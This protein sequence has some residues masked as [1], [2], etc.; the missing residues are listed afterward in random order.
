MD[1]ELIKDMERENPRREPANR[2]NITACLLLLG[3]FWVAL[4]IIERFASWID[5]TNLLS[6]FLG[7][8]MAV[9]SIAIL[10]SVIFIGRHLLY[11]TLTSPPFSVAILVVLLATTISGTLIVQGAPGREF[12]ELYGRIFSS[13]LIGLGMDDIFHSLWFGGF[14]FLL[15]VTLLLVA[16]K[17]KMWKMPKWGYLLAHLGVVL[18]LVGGFIGYFTGFKGFMDLHEGMVA[19]EVM[20]TE[21]AVRTGDKHTLVFSVLLEDFDIEMYESEYRLYVYE[22]SGDGHRLAKSFSLDEAVEWSSIPGG[23]EIRAGEFYP[24]FFMREELEEDP[25]G[26]GR[27]ALQMELQSGEG[28]IKAHSF[29]GNLDHQTSSLIPGRPLARFL[30]EAPAEEDLE[31]YVKLQ[32]EAHTVIFEKADCCPREEVVVEPGGDYSLASG[33][34]R[35]RVLEYISDFVY[36]METRKP[37]SRSE[38]PNNPALHVAIG[39]TNPGTE[40]TRWL[41]AKMPEFAMQHG[42]RQEGLKLVYKYTPRAGPAPREFLIIG[43]TRE[44]LELEQGREVKRASLLPEDEGVPEVNAVSFRIIEAA[45][46]SRVRGTRS[47]ELINPVVELELRRGDH[48][49][50]ALMSAGHSEPLRLPDG[51]TLISFEQ[52]SEEARAYRSKLAVLEGGE[53]VL[54]KTI[55]VNDPLSYKGYSFYQSNYRKED[56]TY[57]GILVV[58]DPGLPVVWAGFVMVCAGV[59]F[60]FYA[61]PRILE[62]RSGHVS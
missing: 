23:H 7:Q 45:R 10:G 18:I 14:L 35:M 58:R 1:V 33:K 57:S 34:Y 24:D 6:S 25:A 38:L 26:Q 8:G 49:R 13:V 28:T 19:N 27:P 20:E 59:I 52:K 61:R 15:S 53:T 21:G 30:W 3:V 9:V 4:L 51:K 2:N 55:A 41:F 36:D 56:P 43:S 5:S 48:V 50:K 16:F 40:E 42:R 22:Q 60:A 44:L 17:K 12:T 32:P 11:R 47:E 54:T 31:Q 46:E 62:R 37:S 29:A 39:P